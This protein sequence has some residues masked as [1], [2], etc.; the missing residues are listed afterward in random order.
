ML[1]GNNIN[2]TAIGYNTIAY[3][4]NTMYFG[5]TDVI[6]WGFGTDPGAN[7]IKVGHNSSD[8]NG[9]TLTLAGVWTSISDSTKKYD[10]KNINYGLNEIKKLRPVTFKY[11]GTTEQ[12][13]GFI[14][15]EIKQVLPEV[16]YGEEGSM[17]M[18]YG[19]ITAVLTKA[20][21]ELSKQND[22]KDSAIKA[23]QNAV[24]AIQDSSQKQQ[25]LNQ[26]LQNAL[27]NKQA[28]NQQLQANN[29]K[30]QQQ[31][32]ALASKMEILKMLCHNVV[33]TSLQH[34]NKQ[35][36]WEVA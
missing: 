24:S 3:A 29:L 34:H 17:T 4:D 32:D 7:A 6:G 15:Q 28:L 23:L 18:S 22:E 31:M 5:N 30:Q 2:S 27:Q 35:L 21:Q 1:Y 11:K 9:A 36:E 14:A 16:V 12:D 20:M 25:A 10:I 8:G 26:Q 33:L 19:Q 13:I